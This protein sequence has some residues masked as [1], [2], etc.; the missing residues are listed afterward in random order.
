M[1]NGGTIT[2]KLT[3]PSSTTDD[4][5]VLTGKDPVAG[6]IFNATATPTLTIANAGGFTTGT[7]QLFTY[8]SGSTVAG[9]ANLPL[10]PTSPVG[11]LILTT[12]N[13]TAGFSIDLLVQANTSVVWS[14]ALGFSTISPQLWNTTVQT[15]PKN[16]VDLTANPADFVNALDAIF[17][18]TAVGFAPVVNGNVQPKSIAF[19]NTSANTYTLSD[20]GV[21][22]SFISDNGTSPTALTKTGNGGLIINTGTSTFTGGSIIG[23]GGTVTLGASTTVVAG[24]ITQGPLG[25]GAI[26]FNSGTIK[27]NGTAISIANAINIGGNLTFDTAGVG[28][29]TFTNQVT[30]NN[31][32]ITNVAANTNLTVN[33]TTT[34]Q[35]NISGSG[36]AITKLG[37]GTLVLAGTN[38]YNGGTTV[39]AG[40]LTL[41]ATG[42]LASGSDLTVANLAIAN[43]NN[44][45]AQTL[46][47][48]ANSG[49]VNLNTGTTTTATTLNG[50]LTGAV[51]QGTPSSHLSVTNGSYAG[52]ITGPAQLIKTGSAVDNLTLTNGGST[53]TAGT[54]FNGGIITVGA[55]TT[56]GGGVITQGPL[57]TGSIAM[58][59][60]T[61]LA[62]SGSS[63]TLANAVTI[64]GSVTLSGQNLTINGSTLTTPTKVTLLANS[65]ITNTT[66][67]VDTIASAVDDGTSTFTF[68]KAGTGQLILSNVDNTYSGVTTINGGILTVS[69]LEN[70]TAV[71][72]TNADS[73]G[74]SSNAAA[75]VVINGTTLQYN[76]AGSTTDRNLSFGTAGGTLDASGTG[77]VV[78]S[79]NTTNAATL[80]TAGTART[81]TFAGSNTGANTFSGILANAGTGVTTITKNGTGT[82]LLNQVASTYTGVT[83]LNGG[84][85]QVTKL[86]AGGANSSIGT[87]GSAA[88]SLIINN[89]ATLQWIGD[90]VVN[91]DSTDRLLTFSLGNGTIDA[92]PTDSTKSL[93]FSN[94]GAVAYTGSPTNQGKTL[95]FTGSGGTIAN[96][97]V[98]T[99]TIGNNGSGTTQIVKDGTGVWK[100]AG[101]SSTTDFFSIRNGT[102]TVTNVQNGGV[103]SNIGA[104]TNAAAN[105]LLGSATTSGTLRFEGTGGVNNTTDRLFTLGAAGGTLDASGVAGTPFQLTNAATLVI[106]AGTTVPRTLTLTGANTDNNTLAA[107]I[108]NGTGTG[109][110]SLSKTGAGTWLLSGIASTY[111]GVTT[112]TGGGVLKV[113]LLANG[114]AVS[115]IGQSTNAAAN[116]VIDGSTLSY[117]GTTAATSNRAF[118]IGGTTNTATIDAS[119]STTANTLILSGGAVAFGAPNV[120]ELLTLTGTNTGNNAF[121]NVLANNGTAATSLTKLGTGTW[122]LNGTSG[123][124]FTGVTNVTLGTLTLAKT[125]GVNAIAGPGSAT[126]GDPAKILVNGGTLNW[127][128]SNQI[129]DF[130]RIDISAGAITFNTFNETFY[131]LVA[132]GG[133]VDYGTGTVNITDP[134]W[135]G[136]NNTVNSASTTFGVLNVSAGTNVINAGAVLTVGASGGVNFT[137]TAN[138]P[139]I[140]INSSAGTPGVIK[141][142]GDVSVASGVNVASISNGGAGANAG[143]LDLNGANRTFTV[144]NT[145][146]PSGLNIGAQIIGTGAG[147]GL[148]KAGAGTLT[149]SANNT[150]QG[151]TAVNNGTLAVTGSLSGTSGV[152]VSTNGT[153]LMNGGT[154]NIGTGG[155]T[156]NGGAQTVTGTIGGTA[157]F[158]GSGGTLAVA[159]GAGGTATTHN[160]TSMTLTANSIIDFS[161][162]VT[163]T[164][165]NTNVNLLFSS[166]DGGTGV[167]GNTAGLLGTALGLFNGTTTL[168]INN[169]A[170]GGNSYSIGTTADVSNFNDGQDRLIFNTDPGFTLGQAINGISFTG[171]GQGM[172]VQFGGMYEIVPVPEPAT[173]ALIGSVALCALIGYR[174]RRR[175]TGIRSR[176][177]RK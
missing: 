138:S 90:G 29:L 50:A 46:G 64:N 20:D 21:A 83:T 175:F 12:V 158:T 107:I 147:A 141:L 89:G 72:G 74:D 124:T 9:F 177:A 42:T 18:D 152:T 33:N 131:D 99:P 155:A 170:S 87:S 37:S 148:I 121:Q 173:T 116:L 92:S 7:Y 17:D 132:S 58:A 32:V 22:G 85:L 57:G 26:T 48:L 117:V 156:P 104:A 4:Q 118:T 105:L 68:T 69:S 126:K 123:N 146:A 144:N 95:T 45:V 112:V 134:T 78:F 15:A 62:A 79:N 43:L 142:A 125:G 1:I 140:T 39:S 13:N 53:Y 106:A 103:N 5:I 80:I 137:G 25:T 11:G 47:T 161:S 40:T 164:H 67:T 3:T 114:G 100:F 77:A 159:T 157:S 84:I 31:T 109:L 16:W 120:A 6:S 171:F 38:S 145:T 176:L 51:V 136:A 24:A 23:G 115:S 153:L 160:F 167:Q 82:W 130:T 97:N 54:L 149:A 56:I 111:T 119:G 34:F 154:N 35:Q 168:T 135:S 14:G 76:G 172:E 70:Q 44:T 49:T 60:G 63:Q 91:N 86:A 41:A 122:V 162:D 88:T 127:G 71:A 166:L 98:F 150:Y 129:G 110:T 52:I 165:S 143:R 81:L 19:N 27:D 139:D 113:N 101:L 108:P 59:A 30:G 28:S 128:A 94:T 8:N 73:L 174:E 169:W 66:P 93:T 61:T 65:Q 10:H 133:S 163:N 36:K 96:P 2:F 151:A 55:S 75:N 102:A